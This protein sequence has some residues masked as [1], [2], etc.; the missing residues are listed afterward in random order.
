MFET[1]ATGIVATAGMECRIR[2]WQAWQAAPWVFDVWNKLGTFYCTVYTL[3]R[4]RFW[5]SYL[6]SFETCH[7]HAKRK[8]LLFMLLVNK[9]TKQVKAGH[10][11][12][13]FRISLFRRST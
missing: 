8:L 11:F 2:I 12:H 13:K 5:R 7:E 1:P 9:Q 3:V 6:D 4:E 10:T